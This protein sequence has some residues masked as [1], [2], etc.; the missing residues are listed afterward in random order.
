MEE[1]GSGRC[2]SLA[3]RVRKT[4]RVEGVE[5]LQAI[6]YIARLP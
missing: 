5:S 2:R 6:A 4:L 1:H 3:G